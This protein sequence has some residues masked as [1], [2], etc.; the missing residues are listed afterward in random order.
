MSLVH[1]PVILR[2]KQ[3]KHHQCCGKSTL[4]LQQKQDNFKKN[5]VYNKN[6]GLDMLVFNTGEWGVENFQVIQI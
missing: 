6:Y 5:Y 2:F 3:S 1:V 4:I